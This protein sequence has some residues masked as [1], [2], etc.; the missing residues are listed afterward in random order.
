MYL[1]VQIMTPRGRPRAFDRDVALDSAMHVF[2]EH[3]YE[4]ASIAAL[5][6]AMGV[7]RPSL[8][9]AFGS[10]EEL[11]REAVGHYRAT[12]G[13]PTEKA[14]RESPTA[15]D[16]IEAVLR[17]PASACRSADRPSGCL[18]ILAASVGA[19][20]NEAVRDELAATRQS[21][22]AMIRDR[23]KRAVKDGEIDAGADLDA[24]ADFYLV[25]L[26][27]LA[28]RSRD[29]ASADTLDAIIDKAM[30]AW[31]TVTGPARKIVRSGP[32]KKSGVG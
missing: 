3:G 30:A 21:L 5:S 32:R 20:G 31:G 28:V 13:A 16:A 24:A 9:A 19:P 27:G 1:P 14:L 25:M 10:K 6:E 26:Y 12:V 23:F 17:A 29:G 7:N 11:F 2:W 15:R 4:G 8:Y 22:R 18:L